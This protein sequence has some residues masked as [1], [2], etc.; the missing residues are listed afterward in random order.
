MFGLGTILLPPVG[1]AF[2]RIDTV[3]SLVVR[4]NVWLLSFFYRLPDESNVDLRRSA[5]NDL[6]VTG[7][8]NRRRVA[9]ARPP[10]DLASAVRGAIAFALSVT[11]DLV[12]VVLDRSKMAAWWEAL[13]EFQAFLDASGVG[14]ELEEAISKPLWSGRLLDNVKMLNDIQE[15]LYVDRA[16]KISTVSAEELRQPLLEGKR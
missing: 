9:F 5:K 3:M 11:A 10:S 1:E 16:Q 6:L 7:K 4:G 2:P 14:D 15:E 13:A 8:A 12:S